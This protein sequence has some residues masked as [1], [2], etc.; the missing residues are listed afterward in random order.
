[1]DFGTDFDL[2][3]AGFDSQFTLVTSARLVLNNVLRRWT[4][5]EETTA[6]QRI[7]QGRCRDIRRLL[8]SR[9]DRARLAALP[10]VA[11]LLRGRP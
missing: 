9:F 1:M 10:V 5:G 2:A 11:G 6:G 4:T 7:Y 8:A 3:L